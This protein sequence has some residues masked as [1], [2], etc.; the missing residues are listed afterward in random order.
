MSDRLVASCGTAD[1]KLYISSREGV[2]LHEVALPF[3]P[4]R[5]AVS[6]TFAAVGFR[7]T[8]RLVDVETGNITATL[9]IPSN[10]FNLAYNEQGTRL[11][12]ELRN[13]LSIFIYI[14]ALK[15]E[16]AIL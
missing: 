15:S 4:T 10:P 7:G 3:K 16:Q 12:C 11:A 1:Q 6:A 8:I 2:T 13:G 5:V 14:L 9:R